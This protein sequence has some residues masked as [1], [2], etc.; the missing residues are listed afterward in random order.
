MGQKSYLREKSRHLAKT[1][2]PSPF[3]YIG[4]VHKMSTTGYLL[5]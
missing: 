5:G 3:L 2:M 1:E 4:I